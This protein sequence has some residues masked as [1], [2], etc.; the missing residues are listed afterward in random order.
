MTDGTFFLVSLFLAALPILCVLTANTVGFRF[1]NSEMP[2]KIAVTLSEIGAVGIVV[3]G[4]FLASR[5]IGAVATIGLFP[6]IFVIWALMEG[7][8][9]VFD[10]TTNKGAG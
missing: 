10:E 2:I 9:S 3:V 4:L 6:G 5:D 1:L 8:Q 7:M